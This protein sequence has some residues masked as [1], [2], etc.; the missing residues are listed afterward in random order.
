MTLNIALVTPWA[1]HLSADFRLSR[2]EPNTHDQWVP[3]SNHSAKIVTVQYWDWGGFVSYCGMGM[4]NSKHT[5]QY[6]AEWLTHPL[7]DQRTFEEIVQIIQSKGTAWLAE[8]ARVKGTRPPHTFIVAGFVG[9]DAKVAMV[10]NFETFGIPLP[11]PPVPALE[12]SMKTTHYTWIYITGIPKAVSDQNRT[13]LKYLGKKPIDPEVIRHHLARVNA[14]AANSVKSQNGISEACFAYSYALDGSGSGECHGD[15]DNEFMPIMLMHGM[16]ILAGIKYRPAPGRQIKMKALG[17][18]TGKSSAVAATEHIQCVSTIEVPQLTHPRADHLVLEEFGS[19]NE[20][21]FDPIAIN[22]EGVIV[23]QGRIPISGMPHACRWTKEEGIQELGTFGGPQSIAS[24]INSEGKIV[25]SA[26]TIPHSNRAFLWTVEHGMQDL[27]TLGGRDSTAIAINNLGHIVGTS[28]IRPG[29]PRQEDERAFFWTPEG[30]MIN[31]GALSGSWSSAHDIN[32]H[33]QVI[34]VSP[35]AGHLHAFLWTKQNGMQDLGTLGGDFSSVVAINNQGVI[36][37]ESEVAPDERHIFLWSEDQGMVDVGLG[38]GYQ[39]RKI[40]DR[41]EVIGIYKVGSRYRPFL[42]SKT[43][44][45]VPLS[46]LRDHHMEVKAINNIGTIIGY[47]RRETWKHL[48][49]V[50]WRY[51]QPNLSQ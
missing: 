13:F 28:Y 42:W 41:G 40:N 48:H 37:G 31:L 32:D 20:Y 15:V 30:G 33:G 8:I 43:I 36:L 50:L 51:D 18:V 25:G 34:G 12:I 38:P 35:V 3:I 17:V 19:V 44:G 23:G 2:L 4:W 21:Y 5:Y 39:P 49:P 7:G 1:I 46:W 16:N 22:D 24:D 11:S 45:F 27:G 29:E 9:N 10:S 14:E 6:V 26:Q 47:G